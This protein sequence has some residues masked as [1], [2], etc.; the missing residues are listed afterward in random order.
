[1]PYL[2][3]MFSLKNRIRRIRDGFTRPTAPAVA[4][5]YWADS[6]DDQ[7][8]NL[9]LW[10]ENQLFDQLLLQNKKHCIHPVIV[11]VGCGTGRHWP[12]LQQLQPASLTGYDVS[13]GMLRQLHARFP[14]HTLRLSSG[15]VLQEGSGTV[16]LLVSTLALAHIPDAVL[17]LQEWTRVLKHHGQMLITDYHPDALAKGAN[18][19]FRLNGKRMSVRNYIH[20]L[21][22]LL[23]SAASLGLS[24][25]C[26]ME[27]KV[28]T[29]VRHW[30]E[31]QQALPLY[32]RFENTPIVYGLLLQKEYAAT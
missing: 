15:D 31:K 2:L 28:D 29:S 13:E 8:D 24:V 7:P 25:Q 22:G 26:L 21:S 12:E 5:D 14:D 32:Q 18:R 6:Y 3:Y 20:P 11:D 27:R 4:Y 1:L 17:T 23:E 9:M 10:L 30:Y 19:T 16:D